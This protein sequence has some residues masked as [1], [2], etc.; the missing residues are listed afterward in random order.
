MT[1]NKGKKRRKWICNRRKR[2]E[3]LAAFEGDGEWGSWEGCRRK[4]LYPEDFIRH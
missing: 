2:E 3:S 1:E 4:S